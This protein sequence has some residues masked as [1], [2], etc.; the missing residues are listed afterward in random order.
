MNVDHVYS[1]HDDGGDQDDVGQNDEGLDVE[2]LM[3][4]VA[5]D[6]L[7]QCWNKDFINFETLNKASR[8]LYEECKGCHKEDTVFWMALE[9]LKLKASNGWSDNSFLALL[10]LLSNVLPKPNGLTIITYLAKKI[11]CPLTLGVEKNHACPNNCFLYQKEHEFKDKCPRCN[12]SRYKWN[13]NIEKDSYN[14]K[15]KRRKRKNTVPL[16]QDNQ[17]SKERKVPTLAMWYLPV[18]DHLKHMF[19]NARE[20]QLL[21]RHVQRKRDEKIWHPADGRQWKHFDLTHDEDFLM[22]QGILDLIL[23]SM[24]WILSKRWETHTVPDQL[25]CA[26]TI[27]HHGCATSESIFYWHLSYLVLNKLALI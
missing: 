9:L 11:I 15:R 26:Y 5:P 7:L 17:G 20:A 19:S 18:I 22:I 6:V 27:F 14:K 2:E 25:L 16:D 1:H 23:A 13:N 12:A 21:L 10:E 4:N 3:Q 8:D 24:E